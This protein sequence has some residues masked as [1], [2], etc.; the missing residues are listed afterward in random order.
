VQILSLR[1]VLDIAG[2]FK[3]YICISLGK[4]L[5]RARQ[6]VRRVP[7]G[8]LLLAKTISRHGG[9][10]SAPPSSRLVAVPSSWL[11]RRPQL[12]ARP[13]SCSR[14]SPARGHPARGCP[15]PA[16]ILLAAISISRVPNLSP[17]TPAS[18]RR[19]PVG[20][21]FGGWRSLVGGVESSGASMDTSISHIQASRSCGQPTGS[22]SHLL[23]NDG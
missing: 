8:G 9:R 16:A 11:A 13:P 14:L 19:R 18:S 23:P 21:H 7:L 1:T 4:L 20:E 12:V 15:Q 17:P 2:N 10:Q 6:G 22:P 3:D 5:L